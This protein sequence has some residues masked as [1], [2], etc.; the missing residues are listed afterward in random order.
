M[1]T[2]TDLLI[3]DY[4]LLSNNYRLLIIDNS[5]LIPDNYCPL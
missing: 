2:I 3:S 1:T 4:W 5:A